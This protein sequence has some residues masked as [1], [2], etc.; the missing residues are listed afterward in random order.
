MIYHL[1]ISSEWDDQAERAHYAP[2]R[3]EDEGFIHCSEKHQLEGVANRVFSGRD[4]LLLL[5]LDPTR[6]ESDTTYESG[7]SMKFPH[8]YGK[9]DKASVIDIVPIRCNSHGTFGGVFDGL[10]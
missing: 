6:L 10:E 8:I 3:F 2:V 1:A 5:K 4:D 9:I 7:G